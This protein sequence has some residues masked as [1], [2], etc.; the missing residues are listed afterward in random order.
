M[1]EWCSSRVTTI[2]SPAPSRGRAYDW[3]TRLIASVVP[4]TKTISRGRGRVHEAPR[5]LARALVQRR[6]FL[7]QRVH[8]AVHVGVVG[9]RVVR[10]R[11]DDR[12]RLLRRGG[13][14]EVG[15]GVAVDPARERGKVGAHADQVERHRGFAR[16]RHQTGTPDQ[17]A[18]RQGA[19]DQGLG[20]VAHGCERNAAD[21]VAAERES[22]QGAGGGL[23]EAARPEIEEVII[24]ERAGGRAMAALDVVD[25]DLELRPR[26]D[27]GERRQQQVAA[28]LAGIR[29]AC[30]GLDRDAAVEGAAAA[31]GGDAAV[32]LHGFGGHAAMRDLRQEVHLP[33]AVGEEESVEPAG[34]VRTLEREVEVRAQQAPAEREQVLFVAAARRGSHHPGLDLGRGRAV[35]VQP[36]V[37]DRGAL[38]ERRVRPRGCRGPPPRRGRRNARAACSGAGAH[39]DDDARLVDR[40]RAGRRD[41]HEV[42]RFRKLAARRDPEQHAARGERIGEQRIAVVRL[43]ARRAQQRDRRLRIAVDQGGEVDDLETRGRARRRELR[44]VAAVHQHHAVRARDFEE[45]GGERRGIRLRG[46]LGIEGVLA[47]ARMVEVLPVLVAAVGKAA[48]DEPTEGRV[49]PARPGGPAAEAGREPGVRR[50]D[51]LDRARA[52]SCGR[53]SRRGASR[54]RDA[55]ARARARARRS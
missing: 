21:H 25:V 43:V 24:V 49:P 17:V 7:R 54:S 13:V 4:R 23:V 19:G 40:G 50:G 18:I 6:R 45:A 3:A 44:G 34:R 22:Q 16:G 11:V 38:A 46:R 9:A 27:L 14:V 51:A 8:A 20:G 15:E 5:L 53:R 48:R 30:R 36:Q 26:V 41:V 47:D 39:F 55:R 42:D 1:F 29:P 35:L 33:F 2:S 32:L 37:A 31:R 28:R 10:D 52:R 12:R